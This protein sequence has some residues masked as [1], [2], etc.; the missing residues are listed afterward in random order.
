MVRYNQRLCRLYTIPI[1]L[2]A[3]AKKISL[4][5]YDHYKLAAIPSNKIVK[6]LSIAECSYYFFSQRDNV[7]SR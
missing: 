5:E 1:M 4:K 2:V 6:N 3:E 7:L